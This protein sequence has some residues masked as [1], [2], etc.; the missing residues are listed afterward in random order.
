MRIDQIDS[1]ELAFE[2]DRFCQIVFRP[3]VMGEQNP[4]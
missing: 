2:L 3:A 1:R 4:G